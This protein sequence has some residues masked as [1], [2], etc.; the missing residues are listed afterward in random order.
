MIA[1]VVNALGIVAGSLVGFIFKKG[2]SEKLQSSIMKAIGLCIFLVAMQNAIKTE[3]TLCVII[4]MVFGTVIGELLKIDDNL[5]KGADKIKNKIVKND[6]GAN[7]TFTEGFVTA[8]LLFCVGSMAI[9]GS[10]EAGVHH[11]Y[12]IIYAK[13]VMD[14]VSSIVFTTTFGLGVACSAVPVL[15]VQGAITLLATG[16]SGVLTESIVTEIAAVGGIMLL[17][18]AINMLG[19]SKKPIKVANMIPA[20]FL[21]PLYLWLVSLF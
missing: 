17:G 15:I 3:N 7:S 19:L 14:A 4:C 13:T 8:S 10:I 2:L 18:L 5:N 1:A 9:L 11:N 20:L 16:L 6:N 21:P 12:S